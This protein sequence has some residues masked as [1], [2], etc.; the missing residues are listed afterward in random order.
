M[1]YRND[2]GAACARID[3]LEAD[4]ESL[5][6]ELEA[7][8]RA[9]ARLEARAAR[10][11][12]RVMRLGTRYVEAALRA[13]TG[14]PSDDVLLTSVEKHLELEDVQQFRREIANYVGA[15]AIEGKKFDPQSHDGLWT[16]LDLAARD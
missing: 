16:A 6:I 4:L 3:A 8:R 15:L 13:V 2:L 10:W 9:R 1:S 12:E 11:E 14:Q 7:L 5:T